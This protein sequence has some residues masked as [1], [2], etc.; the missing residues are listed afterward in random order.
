MR[1]LVRRYIHQIK[2][3]MREDGVNEDDLLE[4]K[5]DI[6]SLRY[7]ALSF[8][9]STRRVYTCSRLNSQYVQQYVVLHHYRYELRDDRRLFGGGGAGGG[10]GGGTAVES[11]LLPPPSS[12]LQRRE[13]G[14][15][16][17]HL[18]HLLNNSLLNDVTDG[19]GDVR[20]ATS[21]LDSTHHV[22]P[23]RYDLMRLRKQTSMSSSPRAKLTPSQSLGSPPEPVLEDG[24]ESGCGGGRGGGGDA[25]VI[26]QRDVV[27]T[28]RAQIVSGLRADLRHL[29][30][31]LHDV[32]TTT[33]RDQGHPGHQ[34][35]R[36]GVDRDSDNQTQL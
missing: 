22:V 31:E 23:S 17:S 7:M 12:S 18:H 25:A 3:Q 6:S 28:L 36:F 4:I 29:C 14:H 20:G 32:T 33:S 2:K 11:N 26:A 15:H 1:R 5:Q 16:H 21:T 35:S 30:D 24:D 8:N 27:E 34:S 9:Y 19:S 10:V 13:A